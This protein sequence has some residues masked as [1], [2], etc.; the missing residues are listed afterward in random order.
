MQMRRRPALTVD[1]NPELARINA[2]GMTTEEMNSGN[3]Y[4]SHQGTARRS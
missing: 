3:L 1:W 2:G 4:R